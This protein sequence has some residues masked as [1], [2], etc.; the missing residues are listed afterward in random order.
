MP[1]TRCMTSGFELSARVSSNLGVLPYEMMPYWSLCAAYLS[2]ND[3]MT[4]FTCRRF[5][6]A[7]LDPNEMIKP[8]STLGTFGSLTTKRKR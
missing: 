7:S 2:M 8:K 4:S 6:A 5:A 1:S 3:F